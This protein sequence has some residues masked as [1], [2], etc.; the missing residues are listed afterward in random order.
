MM[1][2][3]TGRARGPKLNTLEGTNTRPTSE[4]T[5]EAI[6]SI[7]QFEI[8]GAKVLD[9]FA[10]SGQMGLEA[11][12][13]GATKAVF[14]DSSKDA[15]K[16][17]NQNV[18]K[19]HFEAESTVV[20]SEFEAYLNRAAKR[21]KFDLVFLDPPYATDFLTRAIKSLHANELL[22]DGALLICESS[23]A[24]FLDDPIIEDSFEVLKQ[25]KYGIAHIAILKFK[26]DKE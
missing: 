15:V 20:N 26:K 19:T 18:T 10:G 5:K 21:E 12:S 2:I 1:R 14:V 4:R 9:L 7:I 13:R 16:V 8:A 24:E 25:A 22:E 6:F 17:I 23:G 11:L 3:I